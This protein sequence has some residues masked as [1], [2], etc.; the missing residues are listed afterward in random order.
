M[1]THS[2]PEEHALS[3]SGNLCLV[4]WTPCRSHTEKWVRSPTTAHVVLCHVITY[5]RGHNVWPVD[6]CA[7][8][9]GQ[10]KHLVANADKHT[11]HPL[12]LADKPKH[13][14]QTH[15]SVARLDG[16]TLA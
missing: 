15:D 12:K 7:P 16:S 2:V 3:N 14:L 13:L 11:N 6:G 1:I 5:I 9:V 4:R 10:I 8:N